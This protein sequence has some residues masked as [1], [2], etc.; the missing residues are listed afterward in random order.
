M[1]ATISR[2]PPHANACCISLLHHS[3]PALLS[4]GIAL[5]S[6]SHG[7][8]ATIVQMGH[9]GPIQPPA[10]GGLFQDVKFFVSKQVPTILQ[11]KQIITVR[12]PQCSAC[13]IAL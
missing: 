10:E 1:P 7:M 11:Y 6:R 5:P 2:V 8:P 12:A 4:A 3:H 9:K 13:T